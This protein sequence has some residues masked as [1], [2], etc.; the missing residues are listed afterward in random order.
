MCRVDL[1][2]N[3]NKEDVFTRA[4]WQCESECDGESCPAEFLCVP[5]HPLHYTRRNWTHTFL[6][7]MDRTNSWAPR[8][9]TTTGRVST[10]G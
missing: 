6:V 1:K 10:A 7:G 2:S 5:I 8:T 3:N 4:N 9:T